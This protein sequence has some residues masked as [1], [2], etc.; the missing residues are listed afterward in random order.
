MYSNDEYSEYA[1]VQQ[2]VKPRSL[3]TLITK[4]YINLAGAVI[5]FAAIEA[6][7]FAICGVASIVQFV[8]ANSKLVMFMLLALCLGGPFVARSIA[9]SNPSRAGQY[10]LLGFYVLMYAALFVPILAMAMIM[11]G[12]A[13]LI[14]KAVVLSGS[15]FTALSAAVFYTRQDFAF[16][17]TF[18]VFGGIAALITIVVS[19]LFG[20]D[21]GTW[22]SAAMIVFACGYVLYDTSN[23]IHRS[24]EGDDVMAAIALFSSLMT[25]FYYILRLLMAANRR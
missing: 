22:F 15:L 25:L 20:F 19:F 3:A 14:W 24:A 7:L 17:R 12:D 1:P 13:M 9:G 8:S 21:L 6:A 5:A 16:L 11:T 2:R 18:L 4:T 23:V 10:C